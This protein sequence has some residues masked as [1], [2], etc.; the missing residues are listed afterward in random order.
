MQSL[1]KQDVTLTMSSWDFHSVR[2]T[3]CMP[4]TSQG[5]PI[6]QPT[7]HLLSP[8]IFKSFRGRVGGRSSSVALTGD[9]DPMLLWQARSFR[10]ALGCVV[11]PTGAAELLDAPPRGRSSMLGEEEREGEGGREG[12]RNVQGVVEEE[13]EETREKQEI[14]GFIWSPSFHSGH[15]CCDRVPVAQ[16]FYSH[17]V[18]NGQRAPG[19]RHRGGRR[20]FINVSGARVGGPDHALHGRNAHEQRKQRRTKD[21]G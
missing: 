8:T 4:W 16:L 5:G 17:K 12:G 15:A 14:G 3:M 10:V 21:F 6:I 7:A 2:V 1:S 19:I 18:S 11:R 20:G 9:S 13:E